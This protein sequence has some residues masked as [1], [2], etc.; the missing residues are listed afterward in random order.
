MLSHAYTHTHSHTG[1]SV[2]AIA[3]LASRTPFPET[4]KALEGV[5]EAH[6]VLWTTCKFMMAFPLMYHMVNGIRHLV[7][8]PIRSGSLWF[9][10][11]ILL[12]LSL[13]L[14]YTHT[15]TQTW[16]TGRG[17]DMKFVVRAGFTVLTVSV[18]GALGLA[19]YTPAK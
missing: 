14:V 12:S 16:D 7:S 9:N 5:S 19:F 4:I 18:I 6:P 10:V 15:H 8:I 2:A 13:S 17:F 3:Y 1:V 11:V